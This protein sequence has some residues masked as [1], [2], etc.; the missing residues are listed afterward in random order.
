MGT[1]R[2]SLGLSR[3]WPRKKYT[4]DAAKGDLLSAGRAFPLCY[5]GVSDAGF[6]KDVPTQ[7]R[8]LFFHGIHADSTS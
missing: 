1:T 6:A 3:G 4:V 8:C 7:R 2:V 5:D